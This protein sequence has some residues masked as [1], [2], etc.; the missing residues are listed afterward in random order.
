MHRLI[1]PWTRFSSHATTCNLVQFFLV[2]ILDNKMQLKQMQPLVIV[3]YAVCFVCN[4]VSPFKNR[5]SGMGTGVM[6]NTAN[7]PPNLFTPILSSHGHGGIRPQNYIFGDKFPQYQT[8]VPSYAPPNNFHNKFSHFGPHQHQ[9]HKPRQFRNPF[10]IV[11]EWRQLDFEYPTF[12]DRQRAILNGDFIPINNVPLGVDR[13]R[14]RLFVTMP[15]WRNGIPASLA[16]LQLPALDRSPPM[17]PYP[18]W[19]WHANPEVQ[20]DCTRLM[21]VYRIWVDEW[22]FLYSNSTK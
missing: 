13:W 3:L 4:A 12:L 14:N 10:D 17:R 7:P 16:S 1:Q 19:D 11:F 20:P 22:Y 9:N 5:G 2:L 15:R 21:S 8:P 6:M 18:N